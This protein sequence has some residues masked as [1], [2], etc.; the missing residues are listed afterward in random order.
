MKHLFP[1]LTIACL[2][3]PS[4]ASAQQAIEAG[5]IWNQQHAN[6]VCPAIAASQGGTWTGHWW[7][8]VPNEMSVCQI[9]I[10]QPA[11]AVEAGPIWNQQHA[12]QVCPA[13]AAS[14]GG[15][16]TGHW[17]TTIPS[18]MSVCQIR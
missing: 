9:S 12:N 14:Q 17:W 10:P 6:Q 1:L 4:L 16:W 8:T 5:P 18:E 13:I 3:V 7:T 11:R 2:A 15:E